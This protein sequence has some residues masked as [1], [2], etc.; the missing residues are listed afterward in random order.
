MQLKIHKL[1]L[2]DSTQTTGLNSE[3]LATGKYIIDCSNSKHQKIT[4][5]ILMLSCELQL[6]FTHGKSQRELL[7]KKQVPSIQLVHLTH[8]VTEERKSIRLI[9]TMM[10]KLYFVC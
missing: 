6:H 2:R 5:S 1:T 4:S 8:L 7:L 3:R 10:R 9:I